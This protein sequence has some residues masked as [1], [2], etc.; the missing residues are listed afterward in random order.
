MEA[1][2]KRIV[3]IYL[4][5]NLYKF[6]L[7]KAQEETKRISATV[8][9]LVELGSYSLTESEDLDNYSITHGEWQALSIRLHKEAYDKI[10]E[11]AEARGEKVA[12][13]LRLAAAK[14]SLQDIKEIKE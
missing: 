4:P 6:A 14:S 3:K 10:K 13:T 2:E 5:A 11:L 1:N 9:E 7:T 12:R 8:R